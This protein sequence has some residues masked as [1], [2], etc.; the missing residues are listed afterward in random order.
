MV[1]VDCSEIVKVNV[2]VVV[3]NVGDV[4]LLLSLFY[5]CFLLL[6]LLLGAGFLKSFLLGGLHL[7]NGF[8]LSGLSFSL[9]CRLNDG[10]LFLLGLL[11]FVVLIAVFL[12]HLSFDVIDEG[13]EHTFHLLTGLAVVHAGVL[14]EAIILAGVPVHKEL[15]TEESCVVEGLTEGG[16]L[17]LHGGLSLS[18]ED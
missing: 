18:V 10:R 11:L 13:A 17:L 3:A 4:E 16:G 6:R 8:S 15:T 12:L 7:S 1:L 5:Y 14:V 9:H 2:S